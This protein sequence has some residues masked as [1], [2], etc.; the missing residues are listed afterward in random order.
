[1]S[2]NLNNAIGTQLKLARTNKNW[3]L[4][5]ASQHT[6]VSKA[7]LGQIE[8]G[9]SCPTVARLWAIASGFDLPLS[10]FFLEIENDSGSNNAI[11]CE[12]GMSI[13]TLFA[14]SLETKSEVFSLTLAP[15]HQH[16][17]APHNKGVIEQI[18]VIEGKIEYFLKGNWHRLSQGDVVKFD[19]NQQ[20]GYRNVAEHK[21][22]FHNIIYHT[23]VKT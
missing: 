17:S 20:H 22:V 14:F 5:V 7:M 23:D 10:Y 3:S 6:G 4:D 15:Q 1:M 11:N 21:A 16:I 9:E 18:L 2:T 19:A 13:S 8:R 12:L